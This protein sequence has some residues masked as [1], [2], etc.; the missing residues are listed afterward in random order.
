MK[1][2]KHFLKNDNHPSQETRNLDKYKVNLAYTEQY[3]NSPF[4]YMQRLLNDLEKEQSSY[5]H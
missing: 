5:T 2:Y 3:R 4:P 1:N